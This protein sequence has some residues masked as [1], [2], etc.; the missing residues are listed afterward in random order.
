MFVFFSERIILTKKENWWGD[1]LKNENC[2]F[3]AKRWKNRCQFEGG[4]NGGWSASVKN[5]WIDEF[6]PK[7][8]T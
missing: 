5:G 2:M 3:E 4:A 7:K 6:F 8:R 1:E